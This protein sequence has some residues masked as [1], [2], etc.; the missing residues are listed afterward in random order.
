[1]HCFEIELKISEEIILLLAGMTPSVKIIRVTQSHNYMN[2]LIGS[3]LALR[4]LKN[5]FLL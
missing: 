1:M 2:R 5:C 3:K 4:P